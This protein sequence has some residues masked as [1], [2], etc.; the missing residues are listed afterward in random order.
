MRLETNWKS[1]GLNIHFK[2]ESMLLHVVLLVTD[3]ENKIDPPLQSRC[4]PV[5]RVPPSPHADRRACKQQFKCESDFFFLPH[6]MNKWTPNANQ[7][8]VSIGNVCKPKSVAFI[9]FLRVPKSVAVTVSSC[10]TALLLDLALALHSNRSGCLADSYS[11][12]VQII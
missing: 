2:L 10:A 7:Q 12:L 5:V 8:F 11:C 3:A 4:G 1:K 6:W 9:F